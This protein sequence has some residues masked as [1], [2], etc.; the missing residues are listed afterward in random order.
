MLFVLSED[1]VSICTERK[2]EKRMNCDMSEETV[3]K[4]LIYAQENFYKPIFT[5]FK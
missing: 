4:G 5:F 2:V 3:K 1:S